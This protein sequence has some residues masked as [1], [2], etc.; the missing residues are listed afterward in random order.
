MRRPLQ[1][2]RPFVPDRDGLNEDS[3]SSI[4]T[5]CKRARDA[6]AVTSPEVVLGTIEESFGRTISGELTSKVRRIKTRDPE[7]AEMS[8]PAL[9]K[10]LAALRFPDDN[11]VTLDQYP[12]MLIL[13]NVALSR[14]MS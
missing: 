7:R 11:P 5:L 4:S 3:L 8:V 2:V 1:K 14:I 10:Y 6:P 9:K 13:F 12:L